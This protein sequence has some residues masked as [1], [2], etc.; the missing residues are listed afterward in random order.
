MGLFARWKQYS[1]VG[2]KLHPRGCYSVQ[3]LRRF[4]TYT[5][6]SRSWRILSICLLTPVPCVALATLVESAP[7]AP[8]EAGP[9]KNYVFWLRAWVVTAFVDYSMAMQLSQSLSR[10]KMKHSYIIGIALIGS[11]VSLAVV[12]AVAVCVSFPVP[13]SMLVASPPSV[14]IMLAAFRYLWGQRCR[15]DTGLRRDLARHTMVFICQVILT[16]IYPLYIF[17]F[18]S[19][20]G[21]SQ[22]VYVLLLPVIKSAGR[23]WISY[24]LSDQD[25]I[26]PEVIIFNIEV[27]NALYVAS[28]VQ[29]SSSLGTT[30]AIMSIDV[31]HFWFSMRGTVAA[32]TNVRELMSK[33]PP[34]HPAASENFV[35]VALRLLAIQDRAESTERLRSR[36]ASVKRDSVKLRMTL[37]TALKAWGEQRSSLQLRSPTQAEILSVVRAP[38]RDNAFRR[39]LTKA[40]KVC[41]VPLPPRICADSQVDLRTVDPPPALKSVFSHQE[42]ADFISTT[43][44]VLYITEYLVL[45]EYTEAV[46]PIVYGTLVDVVFSAVRLALMAPSLALYSV[47]AFHLPNST[48]IQSLASLSRHQLFTNVSFVLAYSMLELTSLVL[49]MLVLKRRLGISPLHQL[50]F[51]LESQATMIQSKL[52]LWFVY[53]MQVPLD[54][55]GTSTIVMGSKRTDTPYNAFDCDQERTSAFA[56]LGL[57]PTMAQNQESHETSGG[58]KQFITPTS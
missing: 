53:V 14:I 33:I 30:I 32:L 44:R 34:Q 29:S 38:K 51:V 50:G 20:S 54:H 7:L 25:D 42:R 43:T 22:L 24:I 55:V 23:N 8:P 40:T 4:Q 56:S 28:A 47:V 13:F 5:E 57:M 17:G 39:M 49:A 10:L 46:L 19:L 48:Y 16:F 58:L 41:P 52:M 18:T 21:V 11:V 1:N 31:L 3:R 6:G 35:D 37:P 36:K 26:K 12:F 45:V 15:S 2:Q 27:F 9:Y